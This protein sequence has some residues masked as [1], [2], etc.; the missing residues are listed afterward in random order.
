[1]AQAVNYFRQASSTMIE[2][3]M[4][5]PINIAA[6]CMLALIIR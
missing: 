2:Q 1:V 4:E 5:N 3:K 6:N